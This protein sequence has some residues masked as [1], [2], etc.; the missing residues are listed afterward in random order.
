MTITRI[1]EI[2]IENKIMKKVIF[3]ASLI[4]FN[5]QLW[6]QNRDL[7]Q[8]ANQVFSRVVAGLGQL[9]QENALE[10][11][12]LLE[13]VHA[14]ILPHV[15]NKFFSYKVLGKNLEKLSAAQREEFIEVLTDN[16]MINYAQ[17]LKGYNNEALQISSITMAPSKKTAAVAMKL[18]GAKKETNLTTK[19]RYSEQQ[20][21][22]MMYDLIVEGVSLLQTKQKEIASLIS[23]HGAESVLQRLKHK[24]DKA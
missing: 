11:P 6:A 14:D 7:E 15:D 18:N 22:W 12:Q 16:L 8:A 5:T 4:L 9:K 2:T 13:L 19:W 10:Q 24:N 23:A 21:R 20:A 1:R 3:L 17:S